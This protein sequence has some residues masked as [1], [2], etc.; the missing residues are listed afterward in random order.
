MTAPISYNQS[1]GTPLS[2]NSIAGLI[3][4][5]GQRALKK[6]FDGKKAAEIITKAEAESD[7]D[8]IKGLVPA[9]EFDTE[10]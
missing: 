8:S 9:A 2:W 6:Y 10:A 4:D 5:G 1:L 3:K 7:P